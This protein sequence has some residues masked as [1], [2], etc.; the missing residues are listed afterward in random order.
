MKTYSLIIISVLLFFSCTESV[1]EQKESAPQPAVKVPVAASL[2]GCYEMVIS[3][4]S[5]FMKLEQNN[6]LLTGTLVYKRKEKDSNTG[7]IVLTTV[8]NRADGYYTFQS[9]GLTSVRQIVFKIN[10]DSFAEG[11]GNIEMKNDTAVLKYPHALN[12]EE[13]HT[14]NKVN[15]K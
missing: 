4:D 1:S 11:Y 14:F 8:Q 10:G 5:A 7:N 2:A 15:C 6:N 13:K 9:E 3:G 12:F